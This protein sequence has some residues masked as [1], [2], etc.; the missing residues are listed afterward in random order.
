MKEPISLAK[1]H[2]LIETPGITLNG[3]PARIFGVKRP[4]ATVWVPG[5]YRLIADYSW[6]TVAR[7]CA[8]DKAFQAP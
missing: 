5:D 8:G 7:V 2:E 6:E 3:K 1:R 4:F